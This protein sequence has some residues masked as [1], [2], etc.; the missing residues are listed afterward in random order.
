MIERLRRS[1]VSRRVRLAIGCLLA[2]AVVGMSTNPAGAQSAPPPKIDDA[3]DPFA[4]IEEFVVVGTATAGLEI[5]LSTSVTA[6]DAA[7]LDALGAGELSDLAAFT[8]NLEI[9][10]AGGTAATF[11]IRGVG[12]NDFTANAAGAIAIYQDD[13]ALNSPALQLGQL[14]DIETVQVLRG[15]QGSGPG[16]NASGGAVRIYSRKPQ[17]EF[18]V[19]F[20]TEIGFVDGAD[21]TSR[22]FEGALEVPIIPDVLSSRFAFRVNLRDGIVDNRCGNAP[23]IGLDRVVNPNRQRQGAAGAIC[24]ETSPLVTIPNPMGGSPANYTISALPTGLPD[25]MN[26][27]NTWAARGQLRFQPEGQDMDW[28]FNFHGGR[29]DQLA[30][31]GVAL[32]TDGARDTPDGPIVGFL[33]GATE[34]YRQPEIAAEENEIFAA[35]GGGTAPTNAER[36]LIRGEARGVLASNLANRLD[37]T[38]FEGDYNRAGDERMTTLG[39][40]VRGD[41]DY[42]SFQVTTIT[43]AEHYDREIDADS[44]FTSN[45]IFETESEDRATQITQDLQVKGEL[46]DQALAWEAG[47][48]FLW[49]DLDYESLT[50]PGS[51]VVALNR[52]Y[53]QQTLSFGIY[54]G[55]EWELLDDLTLETGARYNWESKKFEVHLFRG[56]IRDVC[57]PPLPTT[58]P[59]AAPAD[60]AQDCTDRLVWQ[61]PTGTVNLTYHFTEEVSAYW[62]YSR[63]WKG[64]QLN[65]GGASGRAF[66]LAEPES[67]DAFE[68]GFKGTWLEGRLDLS[69]SIFYYLYEDYQVFTS[70]NEPAAP[71]QRIV[72]NASD[73]QLY[74]AELEGQL[75]PL[76]GLS[77]TARFAWL[78]SEFLEFSQRVFR[79]IPTAEGDPPIIVPVDLQFTGNRLPSTPRFTASGNIQYVWRLG[80]FGELIPRYDFAWTDDINFDQSNGRGAPNNDGVIFLP[81]HAIGQR[82]YW[83]HNL[84]LAY[85]NPEGTIEVAGWVRNLTNTIYKRIAFDASQVGLVGA[86]PGDPRSFGLSVTFDW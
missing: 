45:Q 1:A 75:R 70:Q 20:R 78:E 36:R 7:D 11:F 27:I 47:G 76:E 23:P 6:F 84:R 13:I 24:N 39:G 2:C 71:P 34:G 65:A 54:A 80:R 10:S 68:V 42:G 64:G 29:V 30:R 81:D 44:D 8:P 69:G 41:L 53:T 16:R 52:I 46:Q 66:T 60:P 57:G 58:D 12:L 35:L 74:G 56:G 77:L 61:A 9:R 40:F 86:L 26:D 48:Y 63:G 38:P 19:K 51:S 33:G 21:A 59:N 3:S 4:D 79:Q 85:K 17:G 62:K 14:F 43:G 18:D 25:K 55:V 5:G 15:P 72:I 49:E 67:I 82:S 83:I 73:A 32:G 37:R 50:A 22:D 31:V 28:I